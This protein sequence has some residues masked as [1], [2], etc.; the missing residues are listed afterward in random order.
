MAE[1]VQDVSFLFTPSD[2]KIE[3]CELGV[4][5]GRKWVCFLSSMI[6]HLSIELVSQTD[7]DRAGVSTV[8]DDVGEDS[9]R[10]KDEIA[11]GDN[12]YS[13]AKDI[14]PDDLLLDS[15]VADNLLGNVAV[16]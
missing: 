6:E 3:H 9:G 1:D 5:F 7:N 16:C 12:K 10:D 4:R 15:V 2:D 8:N 13:D 11:F 14:P